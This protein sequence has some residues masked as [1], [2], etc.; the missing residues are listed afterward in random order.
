MPARFRPGCEQ[1]L[2]IGK[3]VSLDLFPQNVGTLG[4]QKL[5]RNEPS[6]AAR[7]QRLRRPL[8]LDHPL[9]GDTRVNDEPAHRPL[10]PSRSRISEGVCLRRFVSLRKSAASFSKE[11]SS[12]AASAWR[13]IS[14]C[15]ASVER[16]WRAARRFNRAI[17]SSSRLCTCRF[18]GIALY[19][20]D[21][22]DLKVSPF[23]KHSWR[24][25]RRPFDCIA[26][27]TVMRGLGPRIHVFDRMC[28]K[29]VD[30]RDKRGHD[31]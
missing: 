28:K 23:C 5:R 22:N 31:E 30:A 2:L 10:R 21:S 25:C 20:F 14:R 3:L 7:H 29:D 4:H 11:V 24:E 27:Y 16:P 18:P 9:D 26:I 1:G 17:R 12:S 13:R 6:A 19:A 8:L 15:S